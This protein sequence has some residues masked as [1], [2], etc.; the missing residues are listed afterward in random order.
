[1]LT[2]PSHL[3]QVTPNHRIV[4]HVNDRLIS[5]SE[6]RRSVCAP[7]IHW[8]LHA[9]CLQLR[10][11]FVSACNSRR[12]GQVFVDAGVPHVCC[13][14]VDAKLLDTDAVD[15]T[16]HFYMCV[17]HGYTIQQAFAIAKSAISVKGGDERGNKFLLLPSG[18][19]H[20]KR[21]FE[22]VPTLRQMDRHNIW[23]YN[24]TI[25]PPSFPNPCENFVGRNIDMW[26][27]LNAILN[28]Q[29]VTL[30]GPSGSGKTAVA[31]GLSHYL[32]KRRRCIG[33]QFPYHAHFVKLN[34]QQTAISAAREILKTVRND[35]KAMQDLEGLAHGIAAELFPPE[36]KTAKIAQS[37]LPSRPRRNS[38]RQ[39]NPAVSKELI[40]LLHVDSELS[41]K[42]NILLVCDFLFAVLLCTL[43]AY[44]SQPHFW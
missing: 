12:I 39:Q 26:R 40:K 15:F 21:V 28:R 35:M 27:L 23:N 3:V 30:T 29:L 17:T 16:R 41:G 32:W 19:N 44:I 43:F 6:Y 8:H 24:D 7:I 4:I 20:D 38:L 34:G 18:A 13:V 11:V 37:P 36:Q 14:D 42:H 2:A 22:N 10:M 9:V 1:M 5:Q 31:V 33:G 25:P